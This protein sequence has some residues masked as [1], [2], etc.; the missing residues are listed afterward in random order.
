MRNFKINILYIIVI[1][2]VF[3]SIFLYLCILSLKDFRDSTDISTYPIKNAYKVYKKEKL[4]LISYASHGIYIQNQNNL[5][6]SA[7]MAG[8]F[9]VILPYQPHHIDPEFYK[10][11][12]FILSQTR[13]AGYWLWKPYIILKTLNMMNEGDVLLYLDRSA[14]IKEGIYKLLEETKN[15]DFTLFPNSHTNRIYMKRTI[16]DK[17][18]NSNELVRDKIQFQG[19]F[20]LIKNNAKTRKLV[21]NWLHYCEDPELLTDIAS[22]NEYPDFKDHRHDQAI[23]T[24]LYYQNPE[25]FTVYKEFPAHAKAFCVTRRHDERSLTSQTFNK[26]L[27]FFSKSK[28]ISEWLLRNQLYEPCF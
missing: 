26:E 8:V 4:W 3:L 12:K 17:M 2:L 24:A 9:D 27:K 16:I 7:S 14:L 28:K 23:L 22:K 15:N 21:K 13:G 18:L 25:N 1:V 19:G 5:N 10:K 6:M 20:L 11:N